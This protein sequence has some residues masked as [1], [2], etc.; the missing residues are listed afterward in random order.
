MHYLN[1]KIGFLI[2]ELLIN[3]FSIK[4]I[5]DKILIDPITGN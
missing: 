2:Q 4:K 5:K 1:N 3:R